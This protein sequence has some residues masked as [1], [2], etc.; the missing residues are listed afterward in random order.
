MSAT[1]VMVAAGLAALS[2]V[3]GL[4]RRT[5]GGGQRL[6]TV[7]LVLGCAAG[8]VGS[9]LAVAGRGGAPLWSS[10]SLP[11][12][13]LALEVDG[14]SAVFLVALFL[15]SAVG[16]V[17]GESYWAERDHPGSGRRLRFFYGLLVA[18][19][20]LVFTARNAILFLGAWEV[21]ALCAYFLIT[22]EQH[23]AG[24]RDAGWVYLVTTHTSTLMLFGLF[25]LLGSLTGSFAF[26]GLPAGVADTALGSAVFV[27]ALL[28][29]GLKAGLL[30]LHFWLPGAHAAAPSHI[31]ALMSGVLIKTGIYGLFRV[32]SLFP[33][34]PLWW[35][36]ALLALGVAS[37]ILGVAFALGQHDLKRLLAYHS[38]ENI[39]IIVMGLGLGLAGRAL[40]Q[41]VWVALGLGGALL[42]VLNHALFKSLLF[43]GAGAVLHATGTREMDRLGG[44][45][46]AMPWTS[47][48]FLLGAVAIC[49]LPPL[50]GFV[51][52]WLVY[53]GLLET[54][55]RWPWGAFALPGLALIGALAVACFV[56]A[57]GA[58][59][60]GN[61]RSP[62][63]EHAHE[64]R[65]LTLP[66]AVLAGACVFIGLIPYSLAPLLDAAVATAARLSGP[67]GAVLSVA[68]LY[69][70]GI[71]AVSLAGAVV[72]LALAQR[73]RVRRAPLSLAGTWDCG[74]AAPT[75]R[76]QYTSS[77]FASWTVRFF[78][79][80]LWPQT[81][82][83]RLSRLFEATAHFHSHV[84]DTVLDRLL[85]PALRGGAWL[86]SWGRY[87][88]R[89]HVQL[90]L[91]YVAGT[92][93]ALL[94]WT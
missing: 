61:A 72:L 65:G 12:A 1:L 64:S 34:P 17:Y 83:P 41:P 75:A 62:A 93:V 5:D 15:V 71:F 52:E 21:M 42:H 91:L 48:W 37:G 6:S 86:I 36:G 57:F 26:A 84:P 30:P 27:L 50:N 85:R 70:L 79:F 24:V 16:A 44:L 33:D 55:D 66:M 73:W 88:Q 80:A 59:F 76:M 54:F 3:P 13:E 69:S 10:W 68:P 67:V 82:R 18:A 32:T 60:L 49:G 58:V 38:V 56:K 77:S 87:M 90:Y 28:G 29:F 78:S 94:L 51:S 53:L 43:L 11:G 89:G 63:G 92:L 23:A 47:R 74:Y 31:S 4:L 25:A 40:G 2:G 14:L 39:G 8:L 22:T 46:R 20:A 81:Q 45:A 19:L 7:L 35:G 9:L